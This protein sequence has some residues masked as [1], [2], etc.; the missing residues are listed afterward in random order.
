[1]ANSPSLK[2]ELTVASLNQ[3]GAYLRLWK[4]EKYK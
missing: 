1:M 4:S 2:Q 3:L